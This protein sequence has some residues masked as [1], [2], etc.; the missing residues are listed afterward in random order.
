[1]SPGISSLFTANMMKQLCCGMYTIWYLNIQWNVLLTP[2]C[3]AWRHQMGC[4]RVTLWTIHH[5]WRARNEHVI[6]FAS[7]RNF[8]SYSCR[9][10]ISRKKTWSWKICEPFTSLFRFLTLPVLLDIFA[11]AHESITRWMIIFDMICF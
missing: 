5:G 8:T 11:V 10:P 2:S 3:V 1:M 7:V 6:R 9:W 4:R